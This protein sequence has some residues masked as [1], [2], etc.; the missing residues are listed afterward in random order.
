ML[1]QK[2]LIPNNKIHSQILMKLVSTLFVFYS[3]IWPLIQKY[4]SGTGFREQQK[5]GKQFPAFVSY[6]DSKVSKCQSDCYKNS[7]LKQSKNNSKA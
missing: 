7:E 2:S 4:S 3:I 5:M 1:L 6:H